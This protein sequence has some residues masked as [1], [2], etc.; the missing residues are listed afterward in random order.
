M[1]E[2]ILAIVAGALLILIAFSY[3]SGRIQ[4]TVE[5]DKEDIKTNQ[6]DFMDYQITLK[7]DRGNITFETFSEYAP[8]TV[9]N[10]VDLA[11]NGFY[12]GLIFHRVIDGFMIQGGCPEG[13]GRGGPGYSFDDEI[14]PSL[15]VYQ[16]GYDK[17]IV[18]MANAGP[19]TQGS[20]FFI[21][22]SD[23][24]LPPDYTIF[25]RIVSGQ[26]VV[27]QISLSETGA[28]DRPIEDVVIEEVVV[29]AKN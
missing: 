17:G 1:K 20:Q 10:F 11:N 4:E 2:N 7:T 19:N 24:P 27:D 25:G 21:M 15:E 13:T 23:Y 14:N 16:G 9:K 18:A 5:E 26:E 29:T 28:G 6:I 22:V 3:A 8:N 12:N